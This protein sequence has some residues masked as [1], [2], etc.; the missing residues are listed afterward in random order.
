[1][2]CGTFS[3][4]LFAIQSSVLDSTL[5]SHTFMTH[6][7]PCPALYLFTSSV[8]LLLK[9][10][11]WLLFCHFEAPDSAFQASSRSCFHVH[12]ESHHSQ[13]MCS[14]HLSPWSL[15][16]WSHFIGWLLS[17]G[18]SWSHPLPGAIFILFPGHLFLA[19]YCL[20]W[21]HIFSFLSLGFFLFIS[22]ILSFPHHIFK[23][24]TYR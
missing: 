3:L 2:I 8:F 11:H 24:L 15:W 20:H 18:H 10:L 6:S 5:P 4:P 7:W 21:P 17:S 13:L 23:C 9:H 14:W 12:L 19:S 22:S 16:L 1:M